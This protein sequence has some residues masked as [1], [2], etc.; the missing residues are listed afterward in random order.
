MLSIQYYWIDHTGDLEWL[1]KSYPNINEDE[2]NFD[3]EEDALKHEKSLQIEIEINK[4]ILR[5]CTGSDYDSS[6]YNDISKYI[7]FHWHEIKYIMEGD[8]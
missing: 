8:K 3:N 1:P 6:N 2:N 7:R 5:N 4:N